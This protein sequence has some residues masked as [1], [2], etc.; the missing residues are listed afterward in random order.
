ML[1]AIPKK[2]PVLYVYGQLDDKVFRGRKKLSEG[3]IQKFCGKDYAIPTR[4][5]VIAEGEDHLPTIW[6]QNVLDAIAVLF[7]QKRFSLKERRMEV[8]PSQKAAEAFQKQYSYLPL[9][10]AFAIGKDAYAWSASTET[11]AQANLGALL[12]CNRKAT[13]FSYPPSGQHECVIYS[14]GKVVAK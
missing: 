10:K 1:N 4:K 3:A 2:V 13:G 9:K 6:H 11:Q 5:F 14:E 12:A 7:N 8:M